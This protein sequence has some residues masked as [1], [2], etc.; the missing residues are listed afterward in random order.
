[1]YLYLM[2]CLQVVPFWVVFFPANSHSVEKQIYFN[3]FIV[4]LTKKH[5]QKRCKNERVVTIVFGSILRFLFVYV[6]EIA[7]LNKSKL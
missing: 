5:D 2:M 7:K 1:M 3:L 6:K 4:F